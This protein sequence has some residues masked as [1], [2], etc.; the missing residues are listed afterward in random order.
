MKYDNILN[1]F[2]FEGFR[3]QVKVT[4]AILRKNIVI[5]LA[6]S[7]MDRFWFNFPQMF[8]IPISYTSW[9]WMFQGQG[10]C[11]SGYI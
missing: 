8:N 3:V 6:P 9:F 1:N 10:Q 2:E 5:T 7:F 4:V 11:H